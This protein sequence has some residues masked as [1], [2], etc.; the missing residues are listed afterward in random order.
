MNLIEPRAVAVSRYGWLETFYGL[1]G[2]LVG[3]WPRLA[4]LTA[5]SFLYDGLHFYGGD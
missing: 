2:R 4:T 1:A 3:G 5:A